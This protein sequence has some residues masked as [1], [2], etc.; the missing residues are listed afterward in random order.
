MVESDA[1]NCIDD[2]LLVSG[3]CYRNIHVICND[4]RM[5]ALDFSSCSFCWVRRKANMVAHSLA[6]FFPPHCL[7]VSCFSYNLPAP[8]KEAWSRDLSYFVVSA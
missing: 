4:A 1:K 7:L 6:M 8:V 3:T 2:L 5:L